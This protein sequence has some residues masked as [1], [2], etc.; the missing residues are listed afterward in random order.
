MARYTTVSRLVGQYENQMECDL[1]MKDLTL[2]FV[3]A[4]ELGRFTSHLE[5]LMLWP[6][7]DYNRDFKTVHGKLL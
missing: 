6:H 2:T 7:C 1:I 3:A 5:Y 4:G